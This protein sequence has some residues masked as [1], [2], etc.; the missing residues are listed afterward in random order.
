MQ[1]RAW[2]SCLKREALPDSSLDRLLGLSPRV[3]RAGAISAAVAL[4]GGAYAAT[5]LHKKLAGPTLEPVNLQVEAPQLAEPSPAIP[6]PMMEAPLSAEPAPPI[7]SPSRVQPQVAMR[8]QASE[9]PRSTRS[10]A[11]KQNPRSNQQLAQAS[12]GSARGPDRAPTSRGLPD[13]IVYLR[14][15]DEIPRVMEC[16]QKALLAEP[17]LAGIVQ[18]EFYILPDGTPTSVVASGLDPEVASC[19]A[20]VISS[21]RFPH[22][23]G[24]SVHV[25]YPFN[26]NIVKAL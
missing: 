21:I 11:P 7:P 22:T 12:P 17:W 2:F 13:A 18:T 5:V 3:L 19:I 15:H 9:R 10:I 23:G 14:V 1:L 4:A 24:D 8:D 20:R 26:L 16:H 25:R 6:S